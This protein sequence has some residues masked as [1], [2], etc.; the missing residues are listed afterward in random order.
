MGGNRETTND[1]WLDGSIVDQLLSVISWWKDLDAGTC[2]R[3]ITLID[4]KSE[5]K[6]KNFSKKLKS[7]LNVSERLGNDILVQWIRSLIPHVEESGRFYI[8]EMPI[9]K[10]S[11]FDTL[12]VSDTQSLLRR[13]SIFLFFQALT[14]YMTKNGGTFT[15][16][17]GVSGAIANLV[18]TV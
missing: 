7:R 11:S 8:W 16:L 18:D 17:T 2:W 15:V 5:I 14:V 4:S 1:I 9:K 3:L 10:D 12:S 13:I 6:H